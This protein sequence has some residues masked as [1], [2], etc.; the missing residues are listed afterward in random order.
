MSV[1]RA[2]IAISIPPSV[3]NKVEKI[4]DRLKQFKTPVRWVKPS[5]L[6]LTLKFLGNI[7]E[8]QLEET[9]KCLSFSSQGI[10]SFTLR[11]TEIGV[12]PNKSFPKV[13]WLGFYEPSGT[14]QKLVE[15]IE[16]HLKQIGFKPENRKYAPH[17]T[18]GRIKPRKGKTEIFQMIKNEKSIF[19]DDILVTCYHI[20]KSD[21]KPS[22][23]EYSVLHTFNLKEAVKQF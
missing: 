9:K 1:T 10:D 8:E 4:Q 20:I 17:L 16:N 18:I 15:N 19:Y 7:S 23:P 22:G 5:N 13:L 14:L 12:F 2:F 11:A 6:H 21:L 3:Q